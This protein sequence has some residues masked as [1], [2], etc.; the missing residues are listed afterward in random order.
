MYKQSK[1]CD[2]L[3]IVRLP[4]NLR[5]H[6]N[7]NFKKHQKRSYELYLKSPKARGVKPWEMLPV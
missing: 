2:R 7:V 3:D 1:F 5:S 6:N 4:M